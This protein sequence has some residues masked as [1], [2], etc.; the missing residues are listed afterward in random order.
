V[1][2][3]EECTF[4]G[5]GMTLNAIFIRDSCIGVS[6]LLVS[7]FVLIISQKIRECT[8]IIYASWSLQLYDCTFDDIIVVIVRPFPGSGTHCNHSSPSCIEWSMELFTNAETTMMVVVS[9]R[10]CNN[11]SK[12]ARYLF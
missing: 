11:P 12:R 5:H 7:G 3:S 9:A 10:F 6:R 4:T 1:R 8:L 2:D